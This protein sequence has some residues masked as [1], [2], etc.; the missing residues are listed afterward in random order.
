MTPISIVII[1][2]NR[3]QK[4]KNLLDSL[5]KQVF[6]NFEVIVVSD[7]STDQSFE[8]VKAFEGQ[9]QS[10]R[11]SSHQNRGRSFSRN[12]GAAMATSKILV[13]LDD[14]MIC[15]PE[16]ILQHYLHHQNRPSSICVGTQEEDPS[17]IV[18]DFDLFRYT[19]SL[20]WEQNVMTSSEEISLRQTYLT[21]A[22]FSVSKTIFEKIG[23]FDERIFVEDFDLAVRARAL[24]VPIFYNLKVRAFHDNVMNCQSFILKQIKY[25]EFYE[26]LIRLRPELINKYDAT[27]QYQPG[28]FKKIY[29]FIF[30]HKVFVTAVDRGLF[31]LVLPKKIR[32][33]FYDL[34]ITGLA[35]VYRKRIQQN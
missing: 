22:N 2:L 5:T 17:R 10:L 23:K 30:S 6:K 21:S 7:G 27:S 32:F 20:K 35:R 16:A 24:G 15:F 4:L 13:F 25:A 31:K 1:T 28:I 12:K 18:N 29:F 19:L 8:I 33:Q 26:G 9:F 14:D 11:F 3:Q 34:L